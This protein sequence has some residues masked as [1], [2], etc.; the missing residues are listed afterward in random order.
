MDNE[1]KQHYK[2]Y[3]SGKQWA[4][5]SLATITLLGG[6]GATPVVLAE[7]VLSEKTEAT[8]KDAETDDKGTKADATDTPVIATPDA[9]PAGD[10][11]AAPAEVA[12]AVNDTNDSKNKVDKDDTNTV[13]TKK[14]AE[15]KA[16][17][18]NDADKATKAKEPRAGYQLTKDDFNCSGTTI[19]GFSTAFAT[20]PNLANWDGTLV[21]PAGMESYT[22]I[23]ASAFLGSTNYGTQK[24]TSVDLSNLTGLTSIGKMAFSNSNTLTSV[25][26]SNLPSLTTIGDDV[27]YNDPALTSITIAHLPKL[28][29]I[30]TWI[31]D[32]NK[33]LTTVTFFDLPKV[34]SMGTGTS[35]NLVFEFAAGQTVLKTI[36]IGGMP[37]LTTIT[38]TAAFKNMASGGVINPIAF[39]GDDGVAAAKLIRDKINSNM[40]FT[41][42]DNQ[43]YIPANL[44]Y[45]Y[46]DERG[47]SIADSQA[48]SCRVDD[49]L[50]VLAP[51][52]LDSS[53]FINPRLAQPDT[54]G[55]SPDK[56]QV[57]I[58]TP[59]QNVYY[60]YTTAAE[61]SSF[62]FVDRLGN[63][64]DSAMT[65]TGGAYDLLSLNSNIRSFTGYDLVDLESSDDSSS[66][67]TGTWQDANSMRD[68]SLTLGINNG[69][70]YKFI[71]A[72]PGSV[73]YRYVD[74]NGDAITTDKNNAPVT[75]PVF[76]GHDLDTYTTPAVPTIPG[77]GPGTLTGGTDGNTIDAGN[78]VITYTFIAEADPVTVEYVDIHGRE[79]AD[80]EV[81]SDKYVTDILEVTQKTVENGGTYANL[82]NYDVVG[83]RQSTDNPNV[84]TPIDAIPDGE[85]FAQNNGHNFQFVYAKKSTVTQMFLDEAGNHIVFGGDSDHIEHPLDDGAI[86]DF[87]DDIPVIPGYGPGVWADDVEGNAPESGD[88]TEDAQIVYYRYQTIAKPGTIYH[89]DTAGNT[90]ADSEEYGTSSGSDLSFISDALNLEATDISGYRYNDLW[91][92]NDDP[93]DSDAK[94]QLYTGDL[95]TT[96]GASNGRSYKYVYA[97]ATSVIHKYV[98]QAGN[99]ITAGTDST[100]VDNFLQAGYVGDPYLLHDAP[101]IAG[102][103][104]PHLVSTDLS[105]KMTPDQLEVV[106]EYRT[107]A[108]PVTIYRTDTDGNDLG[109]DTLTGHYT[110]EDLDLTPKQIAGYD[111]K[112]LFGSAVTPKISRDAIPDLNWQA[113]DALASTTLKYGDNAGRNYK[114]VYAKHQ[115]TD[116]DKPATNKPTTGTGTDTPLPVTGGDKNSG[117]TPTGDKTPGKLPI[118]GGEKTPSNTGGTAGT[119]TGT[120]TNTTYVTNSTPSTQTGTLPKSGNIANRLLPLIG[121]TLLA[122][123]IG[124]FA[125]IKKRKL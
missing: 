37:L 68:H 21:F 62:Y 36:N 66:Y 85:T 4:Y 5:A 13:K 31:V 114:F 81:I 19:N 55:L 103:G 99:V 121:T 43:W 111:F 120:P 123:L 97:A 3:K 106:Y 15:P 110:D 70:S 47:L 50:T 76:N 59:N 26:I 54:I 124:L 1:T 78:K 52:S 6:M 44:N 32:M 17:V 115:V 104:D 42:R 80:S 101:V 11:P 94:W 84:W 61:P 93:N 118:S 98:D 82:A 75:P 89:V 45:N 100:P 30:P 86:Y 119:N 8:T 14:A 125:F 113:A 109:S 90:I 58:S 87:T 10:I 16:A 92:T 24:I 77:Y 27:F 65:I 72:K 105:S 108:Q 38:P 7:E 116:T 22:V 96:L 107:V 25:N 2:M 60:A 91:Y 102:Y 33:S 67:N 69:R 88:A 46:I 49:V 40:S 95:Q 79:I 12:G 63:Q 48:I 53:G 20:G 35:A 117:K 57:T 51:L 112:N 64:L 71:Y 34:T 74:Q 18:T 122:S 29:N 23:A 39:N 41:T 9:L 28:T 83:V 56:S 73:Q